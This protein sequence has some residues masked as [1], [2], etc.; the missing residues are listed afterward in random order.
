M[1]VLQVKQ[2]IDGA[3]CTQRPRH[4]ARRHLGFRRLQALFPHLGLTVEL[5]DTG[6]QHRSTTHFGELIGGVR[7]RCLGIGIAAHLNGTGRAPSEHRDHR[8]EFVQGGQTAGDGPP[9]GVDVRGVVIERH[10]KSARIQAL[11]HHRLQLFDLF[12]GRRPLDGVFAHDV[13]PNGT[14]AH[15]RDHVEPELAVDAIEIFR[16]RLPSPIDTCFE[17]F[18]RH[19]FN[20]HQGFKSQLVVFRSARGNGKTA[21]PQD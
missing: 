20:A 11:A 7:K 14:I 15:Q 18:K 21:I 8:L 12:R 10:A 19:A 6:P 2:H 4:T 5:E 16:I 3:R 1:R 17:G 13:L 9:K